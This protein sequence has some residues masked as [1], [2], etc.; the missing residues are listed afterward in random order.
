VLS[1]DLTVYI[2]DFYATLVK[3]QKLRL[4][5]G[6]SFY[7]FYETGNNG[8]DDSPICYLA[9]EKFFVFEKSSSCNKFDG[10]VSGATSDLFSLG[11]VLYELYHHKPLLSLHAMSDLILNRRMNDNLVHLEPLLRLDPNLRTF[12]EPSKLHNQM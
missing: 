7:Y 10:T 2:T 12:P 6:S 5:N 3:P 1:K 11:C 8:P 9:P 4:F